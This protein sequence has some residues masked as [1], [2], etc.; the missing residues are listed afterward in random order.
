MPGVKQFPPSYGL[1]RQGANRVRT[2]RE[3]FGYT[4][5]SRA[6]DQGLRLRGR[7]TGLLELILFKFKSMVSA[8]TGDFV[9]L[10]VRRSV[11]KLK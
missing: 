10:C 2:R 6:G 1:P 3:Q 5:G 9:D 11:Q 7:L 4:Y 8:V